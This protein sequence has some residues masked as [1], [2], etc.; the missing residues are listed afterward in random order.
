MKAPFLGE[1]THLLPKGT[2][3]NP[4]ENKIDGNIYDDDG[5][6]IALKMKWPE[7]EGTKTSINLSH[8]TLQVSIFVAFNNFESQNLTP[9]KKS[10]TYF[11]DE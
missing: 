6:N 4:E 10:K 5:E 2:L 3:F 1:K 8:A 11:M 9:T 7:K